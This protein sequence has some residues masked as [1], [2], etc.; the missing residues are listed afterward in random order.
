M[1]DIPFTEAA[2]ML[3]A[4]WL[5]A[6]R[7]PFVRLHKRI[8]LW[9]HGDDHDAGRRAELAWWNDAKQYAS[10]RA[11]K[12]TNAVRPSVADQAQT[13]DAGFVIHAECVGR[14]LTIIVGEAPQNVVGD[15]GGY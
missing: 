11:L 3:A 2:A 9:F 7:E 12:A 4:V 5:C 13:Y 14:P 15:R 1:T 6:P 10:R 8:A